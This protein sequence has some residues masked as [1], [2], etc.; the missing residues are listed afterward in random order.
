MARAAPVRDL[1][2][3]EPGP[4]QA[5][6]RE[7]VLGRG[8][9]LVLLA[10][11]RLAPAP[12]PRARR[13]VVAERAGDPLLVGVVEGEGVRGHVVHAQRD[14]RVE[15]RRSR[16]RPIWPGTS[17]SRSTD[18]EPI[19][20]SRASRTASATSAARWRRPSRRSRAGSNA[21]APSETRLTPAATSARHRR[22]RR[23]PG[24]TRSSPRR[25]PRSRSAPGR[26]RGSRRSRRPGGASASRR[27]G[28]RSRAAGTRRTPRAAHRRAGS[29]SVSS[30]SVN[31]STRAAGP[32]AARPA[33]TTKSQY[34]HSETQNGTWT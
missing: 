8:R 16:H 24:S 10:D 31:A 20:A 18:T 2:A 34:G 6:H 17:Y 32:R 12:G 3:A 29:I 14:R 27:R 19:P 11:R 28:R 5:V 13:Q 33:Y 30:A 22:A 26:G 7:R 25:R 4:G 1:V 23:G 15:R 9:V 21:C